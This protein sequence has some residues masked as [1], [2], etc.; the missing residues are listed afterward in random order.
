MAKS[1]YSSTQGIE[2]VI[3]SPFLRCLQ[4]ATHAYT[5]LGLPGL[6]TSNMLSEWVTPDNH[7]TT[8]PQV[9]ATQDTA[10][11]VFL[12]LDL[13]PLPVCPET[14]QA[15]RARYRAALDHLADQYWP[16]T[17]LLVTHQGCVEEAF[18]WG[19]QEAEYC[20]HV[21]LSRTTMTGSG[22]QT[23]VFINMRHCCHRL[24][25]IQCVQC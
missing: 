1:Y 23:M 10:D 15:S 19:G 22:E 14:R 7:M 3:S 4:T 8:T 11:T 18:K 12:S 16:Q 2:V 21:H 9:P 5:V 17:L 25:L 13:E 20:A 24:T 6:H